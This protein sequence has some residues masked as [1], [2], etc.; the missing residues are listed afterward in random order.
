MVLDAF[1]RFIKVLPFL[2]GQKK[3]TL[4]LLKTLQLFQMFSSSSTS[5]LLHLNLTLPVAH[6]DKCHTTTR[7]LKA[8]GACSYCRLPHAFNLRGLLKAR[9]L[10]P[11]PKLAPRLV[12]DHTEL[13]YRVA[14]Y[15]A[16]YEEMSELQ[17]LNQSFVISR[18]DHVDLP[19]F[20]E[21]LKPANSQSAATPEFRVTEGA[22]GSDMLKGLQVGL[23]DLSNREMQMHQFIHFYWTHMIASTQMQLPSKDGKSVKLFR[24]LLTHIPSEAALVQSYKTLEASIKLIHKHPARPGSKPS[25][26]SAETKPNPVPPKF[27]K[28]L[29]SICLGETKEGGPL[30]FTE[31]YKI[32]HKASFL[33]VIFILEDSDET[34]I[35]ARL[36]WVHTAIDTISG[37]L[38]ALDIGSEMNIDPKAHAHCAYIIMGAM[39]RTYCLHVTN[40]ANPKR[41]AKI[42]QGPSF[43]TLSR[44]Q[45]EEFLELHAKILTYGLSRAKPAGSE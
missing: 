16:T 33:T 31:Q 15:K 39:I 23:E 10:F 28:P 29:Y 22:I 38:S 19:T 3:F 24:T 7:P 44:K 41:M 4:D 30:G 21:Q 13:W 40:P 18:A 20:L 25:N 27:D 8:L 42:F 6:C 43:N 17:T 45:R 11:N 26:Q 36:A 32:D 5:P 9:P 35:E 34:L 14:Q 37:R 2:V 1:L 12:D